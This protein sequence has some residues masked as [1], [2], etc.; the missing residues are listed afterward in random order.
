MGLNNIQLNAVLL[1]DLYNKSLV[2]TNISK[3][4]E[5]SAKNIQGN[6]LGNNQSHIC[7]IVHEEK[8]PLINDADLEFLTNIL[9]ACKL[10]LNDIVLL[11]SCSKPQ[12][13]YKDICQVFSPQ[14]I[15]LFGVSPVNVGIPMEF[16]GYKLQAYNNQ[17]FLL[18]PSL[19]EIKA[20]KP[21]KEKLWA[22][23]QNLFK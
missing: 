17:T 8:A 1:Q 19:N 15:I 18:A 10:S 14:I 2:D 6:F 7:I 16:P 20:Q 21:E 22:C 11:N 13:Q 23:L 4:G 5:I 9:T 12:P 3:S